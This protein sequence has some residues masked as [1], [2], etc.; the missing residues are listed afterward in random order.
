MKPDEQRRFREWAKGQ[1]KHGHFSLPDRMPGEPPIN[2][3]QKGELRKWG[4]FDETQ[5]ESLGTWQA[6]VAMQKARR[7]YEDFQSEKTVEWME[8]EAKRNPSVAGCI[9]LLLVLIFVVLIWRCC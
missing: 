6:E 4:R 5:L 3:A 9:L 2:E 7:A 8:K 1:L